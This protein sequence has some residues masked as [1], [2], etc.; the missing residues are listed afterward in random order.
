MLEGNTL[1]SGINMPKTKLQSFIEK[2]KQENESLSKVTLSLKTQKGFSSFLAALNDPE[3]R[4]VQSISELDLSSSNL[5]MEK[6]KALVIA[7]N[8]CPNIKTLHLNNC[9]ITDEFTLGLAKLDHVLSLSLKDNLLK[10]RPMFSTKLE[11]LYLDNNP[12]LSSRQVLHFLNTYARN[13]QVLSLAN[14]NVR[15]SAFTLLNVNRSILPKLTSLNL[16]GNKI[17]FLGVADLVSIKSLV[18]LDLGNNRL[19]GNDGIQSLKALDQL[20]TLYVDNCNV[21][22][23]GLVHIAEMNIK[24]V[25]LSY[26]A[27][28][29]H[30]WAVPFDG[31]APNKS[32]QTM[33]LMF[34]GLKDEHVL[35]L[36]KSFSET[37][38]LV[39]ANNKLTP[40]GIISLLENPNIKSLDVG[41]HQLYKKPNSR[42]NNTQRKALIAAEKAKIAPLLDAIRE[43]PALTD[44]NLEGTGL[45]SRMLLSL[46]PT[47]EDTE[48]KL[49]RINS[50]PCKK[51]KRELT[52]EIERK[53]EAKE[54]AAEIILSAPKALPKQQ[55]IEIEAQPRLT[56]KDKLIKKLEAEN[57]SLKAELAAAQAEISLLKDKP[58]TEALPS[59]PSV[60]RLID[61][62]ENKPSTSAFFAPQKSSS[63]V[64]RTRKTIS[65]PAS[66]PS[67][68]SIVTQAIS[69]ATYK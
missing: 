53:R 1:I 45:T 64:T 35:N 8:K 32:L 13:V 20:E 49:K 66:Q 25:D 30:S 47:P 67:S 5:S 59:T 61:K 43:A 31:V 26:N 44:L 60:K 38:A 69:G 28:L 57:A 24:T 12:Q 68:E 63:G 56:K 36:S 29:K 10:N 41:T 58:S 65:E 7:L 9:K 48:R 34:C 50:V 33:K 22:I 27:G 42:G 15:D 18:T 4:G 19:I 6:I 37:T 52:Q 2:V 55:I 39:M 14:C 3:N 11:S 23:F 46:I 16:R 62:L 40:A 17:S 54:S 51:L 21:G